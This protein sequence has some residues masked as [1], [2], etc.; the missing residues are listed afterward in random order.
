MPIIGFTPNPSALVLQLTE[1]SVVAKK[2]A[3]PRAS[4]YFEILESKPFDFGWEKNILIVC[5]PTTASNKEFELL[6]STSMLPHATK[7]E[8][9][10]LF[11]I[12]RK[13]NGILLAGSLTLNDYATAHKFLRIRRREKY[14]PI[15]W[16]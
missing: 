11:S 4:P 7:G 16:K 14:I 3:L 2:I 6:F 1:T 13:Q 12:V 8:F 9:F 10:I 15:L 5:D